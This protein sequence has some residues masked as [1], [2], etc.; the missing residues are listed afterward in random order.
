M[1]GD[2]RLPMGYGGLM[3]IGTPFQTVV[4]VACL[5]P[6]AL[7]HVAFPASPCVTLREGRTEGW[8]GPRGSGFHFV[9]FPRRLAAGVEASPSRLKSQEEETPQR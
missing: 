2:C 9:D 4:A 3:G 7:A 5:T 8:W 6:E 1:A